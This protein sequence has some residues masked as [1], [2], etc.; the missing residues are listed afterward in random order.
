M[1]KRKRKK[2]IIKR[3]MILI[4]EKYMNIFLKQFVNHVIYTLKKK[5]EFS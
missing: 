2:I 1:I 4:K 5:L 3:K